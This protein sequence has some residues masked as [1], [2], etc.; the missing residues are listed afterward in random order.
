MRGQLINLIGQR[1]GRLTVLRLDSIIPGKGARWVCICDCGSKPI[2]GSS[3]LLRKGRGTVSCGCSRR[4]S[5]YEFLY[6]QLVSVARR[7]NLCFLPFKEF[8]EFTSIQV[9]HYC[10][11][12]IVWSKFRSRDA[13]ARGYNLDRKDTK[14]EYQKENL[15][16]CCKRCNRG[17][18]DSFTHAEW[19]RIGSL[20]RQMREEETL[21]LA[22]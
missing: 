6:T 1:F 21:G 12:S 19:I 5:P 17:K 4:R 15:V 14:C 10:G 22:A 7:N 8:L 11:A 13:G 2:I 9:C 18:G 20:I 3:N 16:V